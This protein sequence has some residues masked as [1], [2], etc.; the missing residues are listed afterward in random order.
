MLI[1]FVTMKQRLVRCFLGLAFALFLMA[2]SNDD[3]GG[4]VPPLL[5]ELVVMN[6]GGDGCLESVTLD[7][8]STYDIR[9][10]QLM[11]EVKDTVWRCKATYT[12]VQKKMQMYSI[13]RV[14]CAAPVKAETL[15]VVNGEAR[16]LP[17]DP[18]EVLAMWKSGGFVNMCLGLM[19][20]GNGS[21]KYAFC[22]DSV[23][24]YSL[25]HARPQD[26]AESY[27]EDVYL[28][29]PIPDGLDSLTF[30]VYTYDGIY[31]KE[32]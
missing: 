10:Q 11:S 4:F 8:G 3:T 2:C 9:S 16:D 7:D 18:M 32:F 26:D 31:T 13:E 20:T 19:T 24:H 21:H 14:F 28:S 17:R 1:H 15:G 29:M 22:E 23:G 12:L 6:I 30:S 25:L 27:T 5:T